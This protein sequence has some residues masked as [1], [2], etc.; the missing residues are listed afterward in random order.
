MVL[1]GSEEI[2]NLIGFPDFKLLP[3]YARIIK[4]LRKINPPSHFML[5]TVPFHTHPEKSCFWSEAVTRLVIGYGTA[6]GQKRTLA[7]LLF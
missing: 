4:L 5:Y 2:Q 7:P 3:S 6:N 1:L